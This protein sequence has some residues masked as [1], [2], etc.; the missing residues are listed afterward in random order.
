MNKQVSVPINGPKSP[1]KTI[2]TDGSRIHFVKEHRAYFNDLVLRRRKFE[3]R[4]DDRNYLKDEY[5]IVKEFIPVG[6]DGAYTGRQ[7]QRKIIAVYGPADMPG[8]ML[9]WVALQ[10]SDGPED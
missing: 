2:V 9:G 10:L 1:E 7:V 4:R 8:I 3:I 5:L 6:D